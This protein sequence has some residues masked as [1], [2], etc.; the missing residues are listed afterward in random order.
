MLPHL[1]ER[2]KRLYLGSEAKKL[3]M[4]VIPLFQ[5]CQEFQDQLYYKAEKNC[6][7]FQTKQTRK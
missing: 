4:G 2:Q 3:G 6:K 7:T 5:N 1:D